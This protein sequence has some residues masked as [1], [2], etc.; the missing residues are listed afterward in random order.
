[1]TTPAVTRITGK[2]RARDVKRLASLA[3]S[4]TVGPTV[5]Y[6]AGVTAPIIS[7]G[8]AMFTKNAMVA[9]D[10]DPFWAWYNS[11]FLAAFAGIVWY[12]VFMRWSYRHTFG[13]GSELTEE[14]EILLRSD[15]LTILRGPIALQA[16]W[17]AVKAVRNIGKD[18][19]IFIEGA[20]PLMIPAAWFARPEDKDSFAA[21]VKARIQ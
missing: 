21:L 12:V 17:P 15:G 19:A 3:R 18:L 2:L 13:R 14:T 20:D 8:V 5:T 10:I 16:S 6:Y 1:M 7:A 4:S 11:V 9:A